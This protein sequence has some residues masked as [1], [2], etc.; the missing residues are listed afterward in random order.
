MTI[1]TIACCINWPDPVTTPMRETTD[2][3]NAMQAV[4]QVTHSLATLLKIS[5]SVDISIALSGILLGEYAH[6]TLQASVNIW[7]QWFSISK[8]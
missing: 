2:D 4:R 1:C 5:R 3:I 6:K 7:W 8:H